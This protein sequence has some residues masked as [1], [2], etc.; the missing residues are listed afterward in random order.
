M[1]R[2][3]GT[4]ATAGSRSLR[5][6]ALSATWQGGN[7][8]AFVRAFQDLGHSV[9]VVN[10]RTFVPQWRS[11]PLKALRRLM[12]ARMAREYNDAILAEAQEFR[13]D[14]LFA[15]KAPWLFADTLSRLRQSGILCIQFYPDVSLSNH[16][17]YLT[18][19]IRHYD[20]VFTT[21]SFGLRDMADQFGIRAASFLPHGFDPHTHVP[22]DP[23]PSDVARYSCD[24]S[25][26]GNY[27]PGKH[28]LLAEVLRRAPG[29][30]VKVWGAPRWS[31]LG[32]AYQGCAVY[33]REYAKA[34]ALSKVNL[35]LLIER[36]AAASSGDLI[37]ARTFEI[38]GVGG[39]MLHQRTDE[40]TQFFEPGRECDVFSDPGEAAE[41]LRY[42]LDH[43]DERNAIAAAGRQRSLA[44]GYSTTDRA[45]VVLDKY[46]ALR[47]AAGAT[48]PAT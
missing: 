8:Y 9:R 41:K 47:A 13:P 27:S 4:K 39:F 15:F 18:K 37:T 35:A 33:G 6:L 34:I 26:I 30:D 29:I 3:T 1:I 38:P 19:S 28:R 21:K 17:P 48:E 12:Q 44:D 2:E 46:H 16:G 31:V 42:Y 40:V 11:R 43:P 23:A 25:F 5:I 36:Q 7:D 32:Q 45:K 14:L 20:W 10:E 24:A 22:V